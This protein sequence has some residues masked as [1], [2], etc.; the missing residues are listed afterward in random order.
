MKKRSFKRVLLENVKI[1][2][3]KIK[4]C[5]EP[6]PEQMQALLYYVQKYDP[7]EIS[8]PTRSIIQKNPL[9]FPDIENTEVYT[10][11]LKTT[12]PVSSYVL[13]QEIKNWLGINEKFIVVRNKF[14]PVNIESDYINA[15]N[16]IN[17]EVK[18][19]GWNFISKL[20]TDEEYHDSEKIDNGSDYYSNDSLEDL[21]KYFTNLRKKVKNNFPYNSIA[22]IHF[23]LFQ[24]FDDND[25]NKNIKDAPKVYHYNSKIDY[26]EKPIK[27]QIINPYDDRP[28]L[29]KIAKDKEGNKIVLKRELGKV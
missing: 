18:N 16:D 22:D 19:K 23:K 2:E 24:N 20:S 3:Y 29:K 25:Y 4:F 7:I 9:D 21:K 13:Q 8:E 11:V 17:D 27:N 12:L 28:E 15:L 1:Y 6:T 14:E 5:I 26:K 10:I